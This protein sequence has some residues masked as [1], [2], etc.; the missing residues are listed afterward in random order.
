MKTSLRLIPLHLHLMS[1]EPSEELHEVVPV[2]DA[3][4]LA[5]MRR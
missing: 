3:Y 4:V 1:N 2:N 5:Q